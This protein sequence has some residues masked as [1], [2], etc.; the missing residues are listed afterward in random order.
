MPE[1]NLSAVFLSTIFFGFLSIMMKKLD[2]VRDRLA[3]PII[4]AFAYEHSNRR[5][6]ELSRSCYGLVSISVRKTR[7][8]R[9]EN[10]ISV[11][12][13]SR[14]PQSSRMVSATPPGVA[15]RLERQG[16][17]SSLVR[18]RREA[19]P[20]AALGRVIDFGHQAA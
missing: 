20:R 10:R 4:V 19:E 16:H 3:L 1:N 2:G 17:R 11:A 7:S 15:F 14:D 6:K 13:D 8:F 18:F 12:Y 5:C 9:I